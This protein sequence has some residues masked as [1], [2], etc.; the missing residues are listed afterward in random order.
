MVNYVDML[1]KIRRVNYALFGVIVLGWVLCFFYSGALLIRW[2]FLFCL[3]ILGAVVLY[4]WAHPD[5]DDW[6]GH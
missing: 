5:R 3:N 2:D 6:R 1:E 4:R